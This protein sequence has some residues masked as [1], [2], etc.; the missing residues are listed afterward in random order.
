M[1]RGLCINACPNLSSTMSGQASRGVAAISWRVQ[2]DTDRMSRST[3]HR[4]MRIIN[5]PPLP[6]H[7]PA[8][9][10]VDARVYSTLQV[11]RQWQ[12]ASQ[13]QPLGDPPL[14]FALQGGAALQPTR[15]RQRG[16]DTARSTAACSSP[17]ASTLI[18][19]SP[20][21]VSCCSP[22]PRRR[23]R[24]ACSRCSGTPHDQ[25]AACDD[26]DPD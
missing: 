12:H 20:R 8:V 7:S 1:L 13:L 17:A 3:V 4:C 22:E 10:S 25:P 16:N 11:Y 19:A 6:R 2:S 5:Y 9:G 15:S 21:P 18:T 14:L 23:L 24:P 26:V